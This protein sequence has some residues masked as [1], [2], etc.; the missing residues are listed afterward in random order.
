MS[1]NKKHSLRMSGFGS[2][3][4]FYFKNFSHLSEVGTLWCTEKA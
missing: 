3:V 1:R 2:A 4:K